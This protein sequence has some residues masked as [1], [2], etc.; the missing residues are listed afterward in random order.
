MNAILKIHPDVKSDALEIIVVPRLPVPRLPHELE[1]GH[2]YP[3]SHTRFWFWCAST[4]V[5][6]CIAEMDVPRAEVACFGL[7]IIEI[8]VRRAA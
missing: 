2:W 8:F 4:W 6:G 3:E 5:A 7:N 1:T